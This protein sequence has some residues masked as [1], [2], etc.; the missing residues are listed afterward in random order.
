MI[1]AASGASAQSALPNGYTIPSA[2]SND[3]GT[4]RELNPWLPIAFA[5][6]TSKDHFCVGRPIDSIDPVTGAVTCAPSF[7]FRNGCYLGTLKVE[8]IAGGKRASFSGPKDCALRPARCLD[9]NRRDDLRIEC[10]NAG[11]AQ[12][13]AIYVKGCRV[14]YPGW[15]QNGYCVGI[16]HTEAAAKRRHV[17]TVVS[18]KVSFNGTNIGAGRIRL[19]TTYTPGKS[20]SGKPRSAASW[21][22]TADYLPSSY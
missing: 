12:T 17:S 21:T 19:K 9:F 16:R 4:A 6:Y 5:R 20:K 11:K 18:W 15:E 8:V 7:D 10:S 2:F 1:G 13:A 3:T 22:D 14:Y